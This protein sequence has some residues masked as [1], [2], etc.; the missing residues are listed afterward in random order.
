QALSELRAL[1]H[2]I[3]PPVLAE[4]GLGG[5]VRALA[6]TLPLPVDLRVE[7]PGRPPAP[8]ESAVYFAI[9]EALANLVKHSGATRGWVEL[10]YD[11]G[12]LVAIVG[13]DGAG[14]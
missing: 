10:E 4:R 11:R 12:R 9:A 14:G 13:D 6:L 8:V 1:V 5:A 2:G 3:H 7:L